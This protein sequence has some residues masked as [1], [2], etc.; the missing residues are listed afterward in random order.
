MNAI[1]ETMTLKDEP[2]GKT[3]QYDGIQHPRNK[4]KQKL[5]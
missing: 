4:R 5:R 1:Q 3:L 2:I